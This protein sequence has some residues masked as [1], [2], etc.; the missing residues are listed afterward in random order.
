MRQVSI[1]I[2]AGQLT[3]GLAAGAMAFGGYHMG[4]GYGDGWG[5]HMGGAGYHMGYGQSYGPNGA[6]PGYGPAYCPGWRAYNNG[7]TPAYGPGQGPGYGPAPQYRR[8]P[9]A[10]GGPADNLERQH[11]LG[12]RVCGPGLPPPQPSD[13][14][15]QNDPDHPKHRALP[16]LQYAGGHPEHR[17]GGPARRAALLLL[18]PWLPRQVPGR[19]LLR[20]AQGMVGPLPGPAGPGQ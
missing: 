4:G 13:Q 10:P 19:A 17:L 1:F 6:G 20:A 18:R 15:G 5:G 12:V 11:S 7:E 8:G 3:L 2:L 9:V 16:H 14:E